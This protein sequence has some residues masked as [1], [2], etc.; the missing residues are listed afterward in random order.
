MYNTLLKAGFQMKK[1]LNLNNV[2]ILSK[3]LPINQHDFEIDKKM[4]VKY[5]RGEITDLDNNFIIKSKEQLINY[6]GLE[7]F[8][9]NGFVY[10]IQLGKKFKIGS[11][12]N[13]LRRVR[14]IN[15]YNFENIDFFTYAIS[16]NYKEHEKE[17]LKKYKCLSYK[18]EKHT[19]GQMSL[20]V[21]YDYRKK[22]Y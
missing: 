11:T 20:E 9:Q 12:N 16:E 8:E 18:G 5:Y 17:L 1:Y 3:T 10:Y 6:F 4:T 7:N 15:Q 13:I 2:L 22:Y 14:E 21:F 19:M